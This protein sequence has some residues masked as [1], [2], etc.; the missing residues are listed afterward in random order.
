MESYH[1]P[2]SKNNWDH[3]ANTPVFSLSNFIF[4]VATVLFAT[5]IRSVRIL[6]K[7]PQHKSR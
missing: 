7:K 6:L 2:Y 5:F 3:S 1:T 4:Q